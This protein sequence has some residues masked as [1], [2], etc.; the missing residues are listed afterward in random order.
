MKSYQREKA[1]LLHKMFQCKADLEAKM[2][3]R[4]RMRLADKLEKQIDKLECEG[5][6]G[7]PHERQY[8]HR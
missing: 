5:E 6:N 4:E 8:G 3:Y 7:H 2:G 1:G